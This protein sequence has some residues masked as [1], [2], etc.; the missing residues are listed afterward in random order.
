MIKIL[1]VDIK[2]MHNIESK[3]IR[4][5]N[6]NYLIGLNGAGKS[7][8]L[9]AIQLG[10]LGY[11]PGK[12]KTKES[13][14]RNAN[15]NCMEVSL[16]LHD[17]VKNNE[18]TIRRTWI[19]TS[20]GIDNTLVISGGFTE[21]DLKHWV[22]SLELPVFNFNEFIGMTSN[23]LKDWFISFMPKYDLEIDWTAKFK[24]EVIDSPY[25]DESFLSELI[26]QFDS[27]STGVQNVID[28]NNYLKQLLSYKK[29]ELNR[30]V[31]TIQ[32]LIYHDDI[33]SIGRPAAEIETEKAELI[34]LRNEVNEWKSVIKYNQ[35][36]MNEINDIHL[37]FDDISN[38]KELIDI[39]QQYDELNVQ[40]EMLNNS[41]SEC[42]SLLM[43]L[44]IKIREKRNIVNSDGIC[45]YTNVK[46]EA[47]NENINECSK[48]LV[49]LNQLRISKEE[50]R[51]DLFNRKV[52]LERSALG[53][54]NL[55]NQIKDKY[56]RKKKLTQM[57]RPEEGIDNSL[58]SIDF[59]F[60]IEELNQLL[61][62]IKANEQYDRLVDTLTRQ[63]YQIEQQV[64]LIKIW[65]NLTSA[66]KLQTEIMMK[67]FNH[68]S[69]HISK[70]VK[71]TMGDKCEAA[72]N[73]EQKANS[74]SIGVCRDSTYIPFDM[75]SSGEKCLYT[76]ALMMSIIDMSNDEFKVIIIDDL[77]DHLDDKNI[78]QLLESLLNIQE[79]I[80]FIFAGVKQTSSNKINLIHVSNT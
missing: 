32:S 28:M 75:L 65:I 51:T 57:L 46:C 69:D 3:S 36:I 23:K 62:K 38:D 17:D 49:S 12:G 10:I 63:K 66:N 53:V 59:D 14:F 33:K 54:L 34:K 71:I 30:T 67:P 20:K 16:V 21:D 52:S 74:F 77:L 39:T 27:Y 42:D 1:S 37:N 24:E 61:I 25:Y 41:I 73:V 48:S 50:H 43:E 26:S 2:G 58:L 18:I 6:L 7:T 78:N 80:Q 8:I 31:N 64:E 70:Y 72:F 60:K 13:I 56:S 79:D 55:I 5:D 19:K 45:P 11:I 15:N 4:F 47:I 76:L 35:S 22:H 29:T 9:Q 68:M 44:D 40:I